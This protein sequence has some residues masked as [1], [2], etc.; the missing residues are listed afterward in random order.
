MTFSEDPSN[1][2]ASLWDRE[3]TRKNYKEKPVLLSES[4]LQLPPSVDIVEKR[5]FEAMGRILLIAHVLPSQG[6]SYMG[7]RD[8]FHADIAE[9]HLWLAEVKALDLFQPE[10]RLLESLKRVIEALVDKMSRC[11]YVSCQHTS[12]IDNEW[13][14]IQNDVAL[15]VKIADMVPAAAGQIG[16]SFG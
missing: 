16:E 15:M 3:R 4:D 12:L 8:R 1:L 7:M 6:L 10:S 14:M 13:I 5:L 11:V 2:L 9:M